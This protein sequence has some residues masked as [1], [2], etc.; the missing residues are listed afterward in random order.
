VFLSLGLLAREAITSTGLR[1]KQ[2]GAIFAGIIPGVVFF[3]ADDVG[4]VEIDLTPLGVVGAV[5]IVTWA[6]LYADFLDIVP[7]GRQRA[8]DNLADAFFILDDKDRI[9]DANPRAQTMFD[10]DKEWEGLPIES[11]LG[12]DSKI[13]NEIN[14][15]DPGEVE[16]TLDDETRFFDITVSSIDASEKKLKGRS[17]IAGK[18]VSMRDITELRHREQDIRI[19]KDILSRVFRHN[20]RNDLVVIQGHLERIETQSDETEVIESASTAKASSNQLLDHTEK[21]RSIE[22]LID[23]DIS[24]VDQPIVAFVD[25]VIERYQQQDCAVTFDTAIEDVSVRA[26]KGFEIA[27]ENAVENAIKHNPEPITVEIETN[28][29]DD[30][31]ELT[32]RDDGSGIPAHEVAV[33]EKEEESDLDHGS[34]VGLWLIKWYVK[35]TGGSLEIVQIDSGTEVTMTLPRR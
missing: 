28:V 13:Y 17:E 33:I 21:A 5:L 22:R 9:I 15:Q 3:L 6:L 10:S 24:L 8:V 27:I 31:V 12:T 18:T 23:E 26:A 25:D 29:H 19:V 7:I 1:Q 4:L 32:I 20:I 16:I 30:T 11:I 34:G 35:K 2:A 14:E